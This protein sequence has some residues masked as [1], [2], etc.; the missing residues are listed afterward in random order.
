MLSINSTHI[1]QL[2]NEH[3]LL[4]MDCGQVTLFSLLYIMGANPSRVV[5]MP[6][7]FDLGYFG[8]CYKGLH[9]VS[10]ASW[11]MLRP[12]WSSVWTVQPT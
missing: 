6:L 11:L 3:I 2:Q 12:V 9:I 4:S 10:S 5:L 8:S 1:F 7:Q